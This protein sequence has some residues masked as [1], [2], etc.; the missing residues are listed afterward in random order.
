MQLVS[1]FLAMPVPSPGRLRL[2]TTL[3]RAG[4]V[5]PAFVDVQWSESGRCWRCYLEASTPQREG[6]WIVLPNESTESERDY[7]HERQRAAH[8]NGGIA[9]G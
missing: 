4:I 3:R 7:W 2:G 8:N 5:I 1:W 6:W 9:N